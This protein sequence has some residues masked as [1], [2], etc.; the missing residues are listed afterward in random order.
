MHSRMSRRSKSE[1][2]ARGSVLE[3]GDERRRDSDPDLDNM[4]TICT[5]C[6]VS[7]LIHSVK[8]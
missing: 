3:N 6:S 1:G 4:V 2:P 5:S 7:R 8:C